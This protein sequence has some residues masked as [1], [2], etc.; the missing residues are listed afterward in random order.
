MGFSFL[1]LKV[2]MKMKFSYYFLAF[3]GLPSCPP[4]TRIP[5]FLRVVLVFV[6]CDLIIL[7]YTSTNE[8]LP[9]KESNP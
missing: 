6:V 5:T 3:C 2:K 1:G 4:L 8:Y 7:Y 9:L